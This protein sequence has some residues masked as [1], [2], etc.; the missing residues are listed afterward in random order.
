M[1][2]FPPW[3]DTVCRESLI[4]GIL[5]A[6][7]ILVDVRRRPQTMT[8][9]NIVWP[10]C[11]LFGTALTLWLYFRYGRYTADRMRRVSVKAVESKG[12]PPFSVGVATSTL[13][14]GA[15]CTLGDMLAEWLAFFAPSVAIA[16]GW[17]SI[18][19]Q[20]T[21][22]VW[23]LDFLMAFFFGI[24][25][26]YFA[27]MRMRKLSA[28]QRLIA[29]LKADTL[30]L[31]A[32]QIG[33]YCLMAALQLEFFQRRFAVQAPVDS[34]EFWAAMQVAMIG[35]FVTSYPMN[36]CLIRFGLKERM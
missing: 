3:L 25:F 31:T 12:A 35:G 26:Q 34:V 7:V 13:H 4:L 1:P 32:W 9:M 17:H 28:A 8:V 18:F 23:V 11:A 15:G 21:Y 36:W 6:A 14:C 19:E 10:L 30:S 2:S 29:A 20:K 27:I 33:M 24:A 5:C 16:L 22:A